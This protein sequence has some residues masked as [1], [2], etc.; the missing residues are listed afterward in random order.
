LPVS[1]SD[2]DYLAAATTLDDILG[3]PSPPG[4]LIDNPLSSFAP[5]FDDDI[6]KAPTTHPVPCPPATEPPQALYA[7]HSLDVSRRSFYSDLHACAVASD[8][9][10][11]QQGHMDGGSMVC[12]M[13]QQHLLWYFQDLVDSS[14]KQCVAD[15]TPHMPQGIGYLRIPAGTELGYLDIKCYWTST[16]PATILSPYAIETQFKCCRYSIR[17]DFRDLACTVTFHHRLRQSQ[18]I[19]LTLSLCHGLLFMAPF[20]SPTHAERS[21]A[22]PGP[23]LHA[24]KRI[25]AREGQVQN[26]LDHGGH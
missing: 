8:L 18:D 7:L 9:P 17:N 2:E 1:F 10:V 22:V 23:K 4:P 19:L 3:M 13:D 15:N 25:D 5:Y 11:L 24:V 14:I 21:A 26:C 16:I 6:S 20:L 12:T